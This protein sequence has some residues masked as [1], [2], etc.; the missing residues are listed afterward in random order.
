MHSITAGYLTLH[1]TP[2]NP[3]GVLAWLRDRFV[4]RGAELQRELGVR[5]LARRLLAQ[6]TMGWS[7]SPFG[8]RS[9]PR[10]GRGRLLSKEW[11]RNAEDLT[12][13]AAWFAAPVQGGQ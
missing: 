7:G 13:H 12:Q 3:T 11:L 9:Q 6:P 1:P 8:Y 10:D 4:A 2:V 5:L